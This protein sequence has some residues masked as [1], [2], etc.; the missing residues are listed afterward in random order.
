MAR[1]LTGKVWCDPCLDADPP[2]NTAAREFTV[3][4]QGDGGARLIALCDRH[5]GELLT[6]LRDALTRWGQAPKPNHSRAT[7]GDVTD[8]DAPITCPVCGREYPGWRATSAHMR[9]VHDLQGPD[10]FRAYPHLETYRTRVYSPAVCPECGYTA[11]SP[12]GLGAHRK[13]KH[14]VTSARDGGTN[15]E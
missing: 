1:E 2:Q 4:V 8:V 15:G 10:V 9:T 5:E 7:A 14:G 12:A 11:G 6:P 13:A 3:T